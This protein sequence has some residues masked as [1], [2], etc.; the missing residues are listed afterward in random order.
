MNSSTATL[1]FH[2]L[3]LFLLLGLMGSASQSLAQSQATL[4]QSQATQLN[5][6]SGGAT[7]D[8][9]SSLTLDE[10][11][12]RMLMIGFRGT[13]LAE[14]GHIVR[15]LQ[16]YHLGGVIL[17][18]YDVPSK[19]PVRNIVS[20][21]QTENLIRDLKA[22]ATQPLLVA[23]DQEGGRVMRLKADRG[24]ETTP[25]AAELARLLRKG[26]DS[27]SATSGSV[28]PSSA[29]P[30]TLKSILEAQ[31]RQL[32]T[33]GFNINFAP[34]AD[35]NTNPDNP[36][37]G[38]LGRSYSAD[39]DTVTTL[40][41]AVIQAHLQHGILP[42]LKHFPGHG[43]A[44]NDT[45]LGMTDITDTWSPDEL[46]P[47]RNLLPSYPQI[48]IMTAHVIHK[49]LD[50]D[51]P[52]TLSRAIQ[53]DILR[54]ELGFRGPLFSDDMQ[55]GAIRDHFGL[56]ESIEKALLAGVDILVFANNSVYDANIVPTVLGVMKELMDEGVLTE[57]RVNASIHRTAALYADG[58]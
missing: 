6:D 2:F 19:S 15:D 34:V 41:S 56:R 44:W 28:T 25:S 50:P 4:V 51:V 58:L 11:L 53:Q 31:A 13:T 7:F 38:R 35:L 18:D 10:K 55:M 5:T 27:R 14:S 32:Q 24:F 37:I 16:D 12:G 22:T 48:G 42:V 30:D 29:Q 17:F 43:S 45:H 52:A 26:K 36:I 46:I 20:P 23:V 33:L 3:L 39:P 1:P 54:S 40:A 47:Y 21:N 8:T 9:T 57:E 49:G